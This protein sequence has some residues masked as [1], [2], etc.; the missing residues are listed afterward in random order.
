MGAGEGVPWIGIASG[1]AAVVITLVGAFYYVSRERDGRQDRDI[2]KVRDDISDHGER[3]A[4]LEQRA[5]SND[6]AIER[7]GKGVHDV[8]TEIR[9]VLLKF[10][11]DLVAKLRGGDR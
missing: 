2:D 4:R 11:T 7:I 8:R 9:D 6:S 1:L 3:I 5:D 10:A